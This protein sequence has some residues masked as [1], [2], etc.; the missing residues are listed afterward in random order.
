RNYCGHYP[1]KLFPSEFLV[2]SNLVRLM[3]R[4]QAGKNKLEEPPPDV[5]TLVLFFTPAD[6]SLAR[7][8]P[9]QVG[10]VRWNS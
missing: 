3:R 1:E 6:I 5:Q 7:S 2:R 8:E 10:R 9:P 4:K